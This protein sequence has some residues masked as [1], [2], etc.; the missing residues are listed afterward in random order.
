MILS[1]C[2]SWD[3]ERILLN[4]RFTSKLNILAYTLETCLMHQYFSLY[5]I[6]TEITNA[7]EQE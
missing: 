5:N 7:L 4:D 6:T 2:M 3:S 1:Q